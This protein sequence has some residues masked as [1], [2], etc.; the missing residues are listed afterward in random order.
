MIHE[1]DIYRYPDL[2]R[3]GYG[4]R[5]TIWGLVKDGKFLAPR[6]IG[7]RPGW[8]RGELEAWKASRPQI[9]YG[10]DHPLAA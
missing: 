10:N 5:S 4:N 6:E 2:E 7:N 1:K 8:L 3:M 9:H